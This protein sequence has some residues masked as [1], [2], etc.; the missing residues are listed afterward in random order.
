MKKI[1]KI[2]K[3]WTPGSWK[4]MH[5]PRGSMLPTRRGAAPEL[6][7]P[8]SPSGTG[9]PAPP[10]RGDPARAPTPAGARWPPHAWCRR[11]PNAG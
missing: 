4:N 8:G 11:H 6:L 5:G 1:L 9:L 7:R 10:V 3:E 2:S